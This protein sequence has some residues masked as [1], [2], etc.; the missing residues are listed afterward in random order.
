MPLN[1]SNRT[2]IEQLKSILQIVP[3]ELYSRPLPLLNGSSIG[4][5]FRHIIEFYTCLQQGRMESRLCYDDRKRDLRIEQNQEFALTRCDSFIEF[6]DSITGDERLTLV[7]DFS[8]GRTEP[9]AI[10]TSLNRELA[11][12][13]DHA[14]HHLAII[15]IALQDCEIEIGEDVGVA[16]STLRNRA[17]CVQ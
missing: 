5:H 15:K 4:Q 14:V 17:V 7:A 9:C 8:D 11:Y 10:E 13:M 2:R 3:A 16:P 12:V 6:L 1:Q